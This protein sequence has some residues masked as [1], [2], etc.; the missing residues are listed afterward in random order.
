MDGNKRKF[1][2]QIWKRI[3]EVGELF[4]GYNPAIVITLSG[5]AQTVCSL[6]AREEESPPP[7]LAHF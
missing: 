6:W 5:L 2:I 4:L 3:E 1:E 7:H